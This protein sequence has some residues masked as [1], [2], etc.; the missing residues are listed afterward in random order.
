MSSVLIALA[1]LGFIAIVVGAL[2][3]VNNRDRKRE[4]ANNQETINHAG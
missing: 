4:A 3:F 2:V 1:L